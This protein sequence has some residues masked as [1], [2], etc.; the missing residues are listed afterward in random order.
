MIDECY[1]SGSSLQ[2]CSA[3]PGSAAL[4]RWGAVNVRADMGS[5][6]HDHLRDRS[7]YPIDDAMHRI[8]EHAARWGLDDKLAGILA[9]R[10]RAWDWTPPPG[11]MGEV[12]L[13]LFADGTVEVVTGGRGSYAARPERAAD[14]RV[15]T[16][17]DMFWAE[18]HPLLPPSAPGAA[19]RCPSESLLWGMDLKSGSDTW[20]SPIE[21]NL[22][23]L[24]AAVLPALW[25]GARYAVPAIVFPTPG[26]GTWDTLAGPLDRDSILR[27][28]DLLLDVAAK[29]NA[30]RERARR[31]LPLAL[32]EGPQC[33][34]CDSRDACPKKLALVRALLGAEDVFTGVRLTDDQAA[35]LADLAPFLKHLSA[36][37]EAALRSHAV[38][39]G[40]PFPLSDGNVWG[41]HDDPRKV[42][43]PR[44]AYNAVA[45][46][47]GNDAAWSAL[48]VSE[49]GISRVVKEAHEQL[50]VERQV[51]S[52]VRAIFREIIIEGGKSEV[53]RT[54]WG[55]HKAHA[56]ALP[57]S[58]RAELQLEEVE[59]DGDEEDEEG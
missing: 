55:R 26:P 30:Q 36:R 18:P 23:A 11:A 44:I 40:S 14:L 42:I 15:A 17:I 2:R 47:V 13:G 49:A 54:R 33:E 46:V 39:R 29:A 43:D 57:P 41:P 5:A 3:C 20:V 12:A 32:V 53:P 56:P 24:A 52:T 8:A 21:R 1:V 9:A 50:G 27:G 59:I 51:A 6:F 28:R 7:L 48:K 31:G 22:Q 58:A 35:A 16:R 4:P 38:A 34:W 25:T 19:P 10:A 37:A 45:E